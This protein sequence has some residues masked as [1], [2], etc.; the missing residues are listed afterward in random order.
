M[1]AIRSYYD[2][3]VVVVSAGNYWSDTNFNPVLAAPA[4]DPFV[5]TVGA[6]DEKGSAGVQDDVIAN[7]SAFGTTQDGYFK[8]DIYAP[9]KNI[10]SVFSSNSSLHVD[11]PDRVVYIGNQAE[12]F[13]FVITS[14]SI[15]YTK[16]YEYV[17]RVGYPSARPIVA[18]SP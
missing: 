5:I 9:G 7:F 4:N 17:T 2:G 12:Y 3:V 16:L 6:T 14:Y 1:Y 15:H 13:R 11:Y 10:I 8:P 18:H